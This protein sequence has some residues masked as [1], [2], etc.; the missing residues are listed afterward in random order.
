MR[1]HPQTLSGTVGAA[2]LRLL[3][4]LLRSEREAEALGAQREDL[5]RQLTELTQRLE[6]MRAALDRREQEMEKIK[7]I[8]LS[9]AEP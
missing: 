1:Q 7:E 6:E 9:G 2:L 5:A 3:E 8:L 4:Q